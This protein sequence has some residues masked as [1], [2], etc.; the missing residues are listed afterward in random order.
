MFGIAV[1]NLGQPTP[2]APLVRVHSIV[3]S[4]LRVQRTSVP[5]TVIC[6]ALK[7]QAIEQLLIDLFFNL[8][9]PVP[10]R[11]FVD[12]DVT[13]DPVRTDKSKPSSMA[14]TTTSAM[15]PA[16]FV[17]ITYLQPNSALVMWTQQWELEEL[18]R[19]VPQIQRWPKTQIIVRGD[20]AYARD[21][22]MSWCEEHN[23]DYVLDPSNQRLQ[24]DP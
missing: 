23:V 9:D 18:Q 21:E 3:W 6:I 12:M 17:V 2:S 16:D 19:I 20:S 24:H 13:D 15:L 11:I 1:G 7:S 4:R 14:T 10:G 22:I 8:S 5:K